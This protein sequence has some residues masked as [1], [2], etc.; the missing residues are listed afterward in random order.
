MINA[1]TRLDFRSALRAGVARDLARRQRRRRALRRLALVAPA[2]VGALALG[3]A[4]PFDRGQSAI[5]RAQAALD[6]PQTGILHVTTRA[7]GGRIVEEAWESLSNPSEYRRLENYPPGWGSRSENAV[8]DGVWMRFD[9]ATNTIFTQRVIEAV[10]AFSVTVNL[11]NSQRALS[12]AGS[13]DVGVVEHHG[14]RLREIEL[15]RSQGSACN[16]YAD[17]ES[18]LPASLECSLNGGPASRTDYAFL[19]DTAENRAHFSLLDSHPGAAV[20]QDPNGIPGAAGTDLSAV[21]APGVEDAA[22]GRGYLQATDESSMRRAR[23]LEISLNRDGETCMTSH[24]AERVPETSGGGY[25]FHDPTGTIAAICQHFM[26]GGNA[27]RDTPAG[28]ALREREIAR[29]KDI[30]ACIDRQHPSASER[31]A[32]TRACSA[33]HPDAFLDGLPTFN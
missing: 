16:Y 33:A 8:S 4:L 3:L 6:L 14:R 23:E 26:D 9:A 10:G 2:V 15:P 21:T 27:V 32:V 25:S 18:F 22:A 20:K 1:Q 29:A 12:L 5:A 13:R 24:G 7:S 11:P 17:A 30:W 31:A 28:S 19:P